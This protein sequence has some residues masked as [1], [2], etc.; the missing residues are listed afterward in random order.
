[1][2]PTGSYVEETG[3]YEK[4]RFH[5]QGGLSVNTTAISDKKLYVSVKHIQQ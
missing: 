5:P 2:S 3:T 1:M 4:F